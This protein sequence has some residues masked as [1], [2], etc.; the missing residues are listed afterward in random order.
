MVLFIEKKAFLPFRNGP[1]GKVGI[2]IGP[3]DLMLHLLTDTEMHF[4]NRSD[5][6]KKSDPDLLERKKGKICT[7]RNLKIDI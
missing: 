3:L 4:S 1:L 6:F 2:L 7:K 5:N